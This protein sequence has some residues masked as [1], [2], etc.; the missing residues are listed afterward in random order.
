[1]KY[2]RTAVALTCALAAPLALTACGKGAGADGAPKAVP[3]GS[4]KGRTVTVWVMEGDYS[5]ASL[6]AINDRFTQETGARV[7]VQTQSWDG[8][9]TKI[10]TALA[11]PNP[12]DVLD[13]GNTQVAGFAATGG[14]LDL[15]SYAADLRQGQTW[16]PGL[17]EPATVDGKLYAVPGFAGARAVIYNKK[18]WA[19]AGVTEAPSTF[20]ELTAAL[21]RVKAANQAKDFSA[22]YFPGQNWYAGMQFVWD[23]GGDTAA[24]NGDK[25]TPGFGTP[26]A[27]AGLE[28]FRTFQNEFSVPAS[29]TVDP[30]SPD[31]VQVFADGK[32][33]AIIATSGFL[34]RI[35]EANPALTDADLGTFPLPGA[36]GGTQPVMLGGSDWGIAVKSANAD[37]AVRWTKI[38]A[39]PEIQS[40]WIVGHEG[41]V[42]NSTEG[43]EAA[44]PTLDARR[45]AFFTA[46]L[47]S[48]ATP[49]SAHWA[50][51]EG[52]KAVN[53]LF[54][55]VASGKKSPADAAK[56]FDA[57]ADKVLNAR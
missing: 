27:Q 14:L 54:S 11:T 53:D 20:P 35:K 12:P 55:S 4:G 17:V 43:I 45:K 26:Q 22:L 50:E 28:A 21:K 13:L 57:R 37:L 16:L 42:P 39:S 10:T 38:A 19:R 33:S 36:S 15:S 51:L 44:T 56:D 34:G 6:K 46:A 3:S 32:A 49:A 29:R 52:N 25:W 9:T 23:A 7:K 48:K 31:Q 18:T 5:D 40:K 47:N 8:I 41:F 24:K 30:A 1:M 2:F